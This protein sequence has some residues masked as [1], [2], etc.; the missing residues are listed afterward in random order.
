M[1]LRPLL[2]FLFAVLSSLGCSFRIQVERDAVEYNKAAERVQ[3]EQL[4][5]NIVRAAQRQPMTFT[6]L[7]LIRGNIK[8]TVGAN[9]MVPTGGAATDLYTTTPKLEYS[10]NPSFDVAVLDSQEFMKGIMTPVELKLIR[11]YWEQGWPK[12]MLLYLFIQ[13]VEVIKK[14]AGVGKGDE[15]LYTYKNYPPD[16]VQFDQFK[17]L[18]TTLVGHPDG[19]LID[20]T[21][22][23]QV[24]PLGP[25]LTVAAVSNLEQLV[26]T[27]E[28]KLSLKDLKN[29]TYQLERTRKEVVFSGVRPLTGLTYR[30]GNLLAEPLKEVPEIMGLTI[31]PQPQE[32]VQEPKGNPILKFYIRS[33]EAILY[34][35]GE[36]VRSTAEGVRIRTSTGWDEGEYQ[37]ALIMTDNAPSP[38]FLARAGTRYEDAAVSVFYDGVRYII[39]RNPETGRGVG[40]STHCLQLLSQ[41][42]ALHKS[43]KEL[44]TTAATVLLGQ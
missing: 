30:P 22:R 17:S 38:L 31:A 27:H 15:L 35:L 29:G 19:P 1:K 39:P 23:S 42:Y 6:A 10:S 24:E 44:P 8:G 16:H 26:K 36:I 12:S 21:I 34:Y 18:V 5:L 7:T 9:T 13:K 3:N 11:H 43:S 40:R 37:P 25:P 32:Q 4:L 2:T 28:A 14:A 20:I 41:I 33:P